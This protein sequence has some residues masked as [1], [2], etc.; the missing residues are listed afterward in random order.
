MINK[1]DLQDIINK[2]HLNGRVDSVKWEIKDGDLNIN[3]EDMAP[4]IVGS[5]KVGNIGLDDWKIGIGDTS[6]LLKFLNILS[7]DLHISFEERNNIKTQLIIDDS[8]FNIKYWLIDFEST[9]DVSELNFTPEVDAEINLEF[10]DI[11]AL[12]KANQAIDKEDSKL[13]L[14]QADKNLDGED[15][16]NFIFGD[17]SNAYSNKITY[18]IRAQLYNNFSSKIKFDSTIMRDIINANKKCESGRILYDSKG[19]M[20]YEFKEGESNTEYYVLPKE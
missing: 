5:L 19:I 13:V 4:S 7:D 1:T 16:I 15:I 20:H 12:L 10:S 11:E 6:K 2:Y 18:S 3:F 9:P 17:S 8:R 14:I